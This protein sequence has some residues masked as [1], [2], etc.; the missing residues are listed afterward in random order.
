MNV[1]FEWIFLVIS[2]EILWTFVL[3]VDFSAFLMDL[4]N[5]L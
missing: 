3:N 5:G 2:M 4:I 1:N